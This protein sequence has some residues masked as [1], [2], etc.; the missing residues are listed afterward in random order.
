MLCAR[1]LQTSIADSVH[2][3]LKDQISAMQLDPF[4]EVT[5]KT[6]ISKTTG[7]EIIFKGIRNNV[8]EIKSTEG[9]DLCWVE[10]AQSVSKDSWDLLIP[11]IRKADSEIWISFNPDLEEDATVQYFIKEPRADSIV[12]QVSWEDNKHFPDVL[13]QERRYLLKKDPIA[14]QHVWEGGFRKISDAII[15]KNRVE[16][17]SFLPPEKVRYFHGVDWGFANDPFACIRFYIHD[18]CLFIEREVFGYGVEID[19]IPALLDNSMPGIRNWPIKA[20]NARPE[21]ISYVR[22]RG[23][24]I[25]AAE[26]WKGSVEDGIAHLKAF[27][28]IIIHER[29]KQM[30][31]EARLYSYKVDK[32][33]LDSNGQPVVL[34]IIV[35]AHNHGWD[36]IRYG[37][38]GYIQTRGGLGIWEN[39]V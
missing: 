10:E 18:E 13:E 29:C 23:F 37:L 9:I 1:E 32:K 15:F 14:Y 34:P 26:K 8:Q 5:Q 28:K 36:A 31:Q 17:D 3:L 2:K 27:K 16:Y 24:M 22:R 12:Q 35:D 39:L 38:D 4:F 21:S 11:T 7:S 6:I 30:G 20:D 33:Q 19:E 25:D